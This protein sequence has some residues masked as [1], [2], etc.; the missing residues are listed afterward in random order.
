[1]RNNILI[2]LFIIILASC[3]FTKDNI[4][5]TETIKWNSK[6]SIKMLDKSDYK[7]DFYELS[8]FF[9][10]QINPLYCGIAS[11]VII[12]N[13]INANKDISS[14]AKLEV[15]KPEIFG[16]GIIPFKSYSQLT[17][18][19]EQTDIIKD[20]D[21]IN[22]S[23]INDKKENIDP[24]L[25]LK[26][27]QNILKTYNLDVQKYHVKNNSIQ[28]LNFFREKVKK[29]TSDKKRYLLLNFNGKKIGLTTGGHISPL[30]AYNKKY[31]SVLMMDVAGH[32]NSWYW[33]KIK[34]IF[35]A[36]H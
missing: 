10:P 2:T 35:K 33:V 26:Q 34:D 15:K 14:Q 12:L 9:Q 5:Q 27:L 19:N 7:Q 4:H 17:F 8:P 32:K 13:T 3:S 28:E 21:I 16:G 1:M 31:D 20:K 6:E 36:M 11:S 23:N 24:G 22:M 29:I 18:L 25:T 30:V